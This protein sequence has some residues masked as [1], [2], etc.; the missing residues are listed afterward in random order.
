MHG[1]YDDDVNVHYNNV[2]KNEVA[3]F[4]FNGKN[5]DIT[6]DTN[7]DSMNESKLSVHVCM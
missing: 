4:F 7:N 6:L 5:R 3:H 1:N 2:I